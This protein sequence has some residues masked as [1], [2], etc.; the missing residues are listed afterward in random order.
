MNRSHPTPFALALSACKDRID[1]ETGAVV[2][3]LSGNPQK[4]VFIQPEVCYA[5]SHEECEELAMD[6]CLMHFPIEQGYYAHMASSKAFWMETH[7]LP[8]SATSLQYIISKEK[9]A[10]QTVNEPEVVPSSDDGSELR[11]TLENIAKDNFYGT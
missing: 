3:D 5:A 1:N 7:R 4:D 11:E 8:M 10:A 9:Q 6:M 2:K